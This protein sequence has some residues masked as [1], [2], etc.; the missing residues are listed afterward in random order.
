MHCFL[1]NVDCAT[2][3]V[4]LSLLQLMLAMQPSFQVTLLLLSVSGGLFSR[5]SNARCDYN[6]SDK[7]ERARRAAINKFDD[8]ELVKSAT[9]NV[10]NKFD[11]DS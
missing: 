4:S 2:L 3:F 5:R 6:G 7:S 9:N 1:C 11:V 8:R 10:E